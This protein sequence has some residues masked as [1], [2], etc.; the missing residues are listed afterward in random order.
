MKKQTLRLGEILLREGILTA[1]QLDKALKAQQKNKG[2]FLG[3]VLIQ[4]G[5]ITEKNLAT[6]LS[7]QLGIPY[8]A[9]ENWRIN[10]SQVR[11]LTQLVPESFARKNYA[12]PLSQN[13]RSLT[14]AMVDPTDV[15]ILDNLRKVTGCEI[16]AIIA[17]KSDIESGMDG[18]YGEG[19]QLKSVIA[20]SYEGEEAEAEQQKARESS[21]ADAEKGP[22]IQL[23]NLLIQQAVKSRASDIHIE[24]LDKGI[25]IRFRV[26]GVLHAIAPPDRSMFSPLISRIK[27]LSKLDIAEKRLPQDG[28]FSATVDNHIIDFRVSTIP[29]IYGEKVVLRILD[30]SAVKLD[31]EKLGFEK[32]DL[33]TF[34]QTIRKPYGL[35]L[36]TGPTGSGKT[37]TLYSALNEIKGEHLNVTTIEDPVEYQMPGINQVE[38]KPSIGLTFAAGLRSFLRQDPDAMLVGEIRDLETCQICVRAA[39]TGH[40][41]FSTIHTNDSAT[42]VNRLVDIGVEQFMV[43]SSLS[44]I[45][46]QRL[47]RKLCGKC[48]E[49]TSIPKTSALIKEYKLNT[50]ATVYKPVG[51]EAC[52]K[53]GFSGRMA[54]YEIMSITEKLKEMITGKASALEIKTEARKTGMTTLAESAL[55]KVLSGETSFEE[56]LR[57]ILTDAS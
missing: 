48:K 43:A 34:R 29:T 37:T 20:A 55:K 1:D 10:A 16:D 52:G 26:D 25:S 31:L 41:V 15:M 12:L 50:S 2:E 23:A 45:V 46:A 54:V 33:E 51:C 28:S 8:V 53:T 47:L 36:I 5:L 18:I 27:I 6:A 57:V 56:V 32:N 21:A 40:L 11:A 9:K 3:S 38:A 17:T 39:L 13:G 42:T 4:L 35:I 22:V 19:G 24:P 49:A 30:R 7:N 14:V 44:M